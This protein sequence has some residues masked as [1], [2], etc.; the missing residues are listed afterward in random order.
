VLSFPNACLIIA[1]LSVTLFSKICTKCYATCC[2]IHLE[3]A[4]GRIHVH[5]A[6]WNFVRWLPRY[7]SAISTAV[8]KAEPGY[9]LACIALLGVLKVHNAQQ[10]P[11]A[12]NL[13]WIH[14]WR[15]LWRALNPRQ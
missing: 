7:A 6:A 5:P 11:V 13:S 1:R 10:R 8:Q 4:S 14:M 2:R 12:I 9:H 15:I 3:I